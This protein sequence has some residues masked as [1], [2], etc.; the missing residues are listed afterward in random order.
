MIRWHP[1]IPTC[2]GKAG[3]VLKP[4]VTAHLQFRLPGPAAF[5]HETGPGSACSGF[6]PLRPL[7]PPEPLSPAMQGTVRRPTELA[8]G[9]PSEGARFSNPAWPILA[10]LQNPVQRP[11]RGNGRAQ[12]RQHSRSP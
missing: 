4:R 9:A 11:T 12:C 1:E 3:G 7:K 10:G 2:T 8:P 5:P 6:L